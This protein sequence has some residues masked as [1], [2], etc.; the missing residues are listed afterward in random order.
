MDAFNCGVIQACYIMQHRVSN[1]THKLIV[2]HDDRVF[3]EP[4]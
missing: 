2:T 3:L 1:P 4:Q